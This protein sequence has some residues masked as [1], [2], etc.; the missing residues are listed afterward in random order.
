ML[1]TQT[2]T[3]ESEDLDE[4]EDRDEENYVTQNGVI[5]KEKPTDGVY[6]FHSPEKLLKITYKNG[7]RNGP[8]LIYD[9][10]G[11]LLTRINY[12]D[13]NL[14]GPAAEYHSNGK[15]RIVFS[16]KNNLKDGPLTVYSPNGVKLFETTYAKNVIEGKFTA[17]DMFGDV[18]QVSNYKNNEKHGTSTTYF[19]KSY[20]G[21]VCQISHYE[22]GL[23]S[24]D[25]QLFYTTGEPLQSTTYDQGKAQTY[26]VTYDKSGKTLVDPSSK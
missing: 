17:Y 9:K 6:E 26:P 11:K 18:S 25:D 7:K 3:L 21:Q 22:N 19:P 2:M 14:D 12:V 4:K 15:E 23:L 13:D 8:M 16:F 20:G 10:E 24:N 1:D 5:I